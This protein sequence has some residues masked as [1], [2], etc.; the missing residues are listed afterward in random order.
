MGICISNKCE[1]KSDEVALDHNSNKPQLVH[2]SKKH[3]SVHEARNP[4]KKI[5]QILVTSEDASKDYSENFEKVE[6]KVSKENIEFI[7]RSLKDSFVFF[8]LTDAEF[9]EIIANMFFGKVKTG[10]YVFKQDDESNSFFLIDNG[11]FEVIIS[12]DI[13]KTMRKGSCFGELGLLY[14]AKRSASLRAKEDSFIWGIERR[15]FKKIIQVL[16]VSEYE[17]NRSFLDK[18]PL[19][20]GLTNFQKDTLASNLTT[21]KF[22]PGQNIVNKHDKADSYYLIKS[23]VVEC[24][25][26][27]KLIRELQQSDSFGEQ[28]LYE[29]GRRTLTVKAKV[30]T[31]CMA[32][33]RE[34]LISVFGDNIDDVVSKNSIMWILSNDPIFKK[35]NKLQIQKWANNSTIIK[36][37]VETPQILENEHLLL[38]NFYIVLDGYLSYNKQL[39]KKGEIFGKNLADSVLEEEKPLKHDLLVSNAK[40][41]VISRLDLYKLFKIMSLADIFKRNYETEERR[42]TFVPQNKI[43][44]PDSIKLEDLI[45]VRTLGEGQFGIVSL[46]IHKSAGETKLFALKSISRAKIA[47]FGIESHIINEKMILEESNHPQIIHLIKAFKDDKAIH[48][49]T[50][51]INGIEMFDMIRQVD[52]L[53]NYDSKFYIGSIIMCLEYLHNKNIVYRDLKPENMMIDDKGYLHLIDL[54]TAKKLDKNRTFTIIGTPHYMAPEIV[55]SKGYGTMVDLWSLGVCMFEFMCGFVPFGE[56]EDDPFNVYKI[57]INAKLQ[58]PPYFITPENSNAKAFVTLLLNKVPEVRL[59]SSYTGL[60]AHKWFDDFDWVS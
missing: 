1:K 38:Q 59:N 4:R 20:D 31:R 32:L 16:N 54:G 25:D 28:A 57:I 12:G 23:G 8:N 24:F 49:L 46:V 14:N 29:D 9:E 37:E 15:I 18:V 55:V 48:F 3:P 56:D 17:E 11:V 58:F 39:I 21:Q 27:D 44:T 13:K 6:K 41:A 47:Q 19:F 26:D 22:L 42:R 50:T 53:E 36:V 43:V 45:Y 2:K 34:T 7:M 52:L 60:K 40:Y 35:L 5:A 10:E 30:E 51:F 33:S